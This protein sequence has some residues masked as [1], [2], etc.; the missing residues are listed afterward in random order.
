MTENLQLEDENHL[1]PSL[2]W[3]LLGGEEWGRR[4]PIR[5]KENSQDKPTHHWKLQSCQAAA[6]WPLRS[7]RGQTRTLHLQQEPAETA[8]TELIDEGDQEGHVLVLTEDMEELQELHLFSG[9]QK[10]WYEWKKSSQ[11]KDRPSPPLSSFIPCPP[12]S[13]VQESFTDTCHWFNYRD[14][15]NDFFIV[16]QRKQ[17]L[18]RTSLLV[19]WYL[20]TS[21][22]AEFTSDLSVSVFFHDTRVVVV[23]CDNCEA[24]KKKKKLSYWLKSK[25]KIVLF[26]EKQNK[27]WNGRLLKKSKSVDLS[28][29]IISRLIAYKSLN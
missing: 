3:M 2:C 26:D 19:T 4:M 1:A 9:K 10:I 5:N 6:V 12:R 22:A 11:R 27:T 14:S 7:P 20:F 18:K 21:S 16:L 29:W 17:L 25:C 8:G 23:S 28:V 15:I 13:L 24:I